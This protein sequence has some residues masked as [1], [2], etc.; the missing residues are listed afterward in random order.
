MKFNFPLLFSKFVRKRNASYDGDPNGDYVVAE[1]V[2]ELQE[3]IERIEQ[4]MGIEELDQS[5]SSSLKTKA[6]KADVNDFGS[7][8]FINYTGASIN[9]YDS[10]EKRISA[11]S[12]IPHVILRKEE[13]SSFDFFLNEVK[14]SGTRLYGIVDCANLTVS[15]AEY[16]IDWFKAKGFHGIFLDSFGF[17]SGLD[18][19][20][21]NH[22]LQYIHSRMLVAILTGDIETNV[23]NKPHSKNPYQQELSIFEGDI[24]LSRNVFV[25]DGIKN[26]PSIISSKVLQLNKAQQEKGISI[27]VED[28]ADIVNDNRLLYLYGKMLS[29]LYNFDG[30][31]L[32]PKSRYSLN[33]KVERYLHGFELG[34]WKAET[35]IY[36]EDTTKVERSFAKGKIVFDKVNNQCAVEGVGLNPLIYTWHEKQIPGT[37][38]ELESA[39]YTNGVTS[40]IVSA[41]ND[42]TNG[43]LIHYSKIDGLSGDGSNPE[44]IKD[45]VVRA[46]NNSPAAY[47]K[48]P[49]AGFDAVAGNDFIHGG[50]IDYIDA[51]SI[52]SGSM[53]IDVL[54]ANVVEA[55]NAYIGT[56]EIDVAKIGELTAEHIQSSVVDAINL[57]A[58][59]AAIG[60]AV[61]DQAAI[62]ALTSQHIETAVIDAINANI[63]RAFIDG[64]IIERSTV[65]STQIA[66][67]SITDAKIVSLVANKIVAGI[68]DTALVTLQGDNG[69]LRITGN[70]LQVFDDQ[71]VPIERISIGDVNADGT[72]YGL[73]VRGAD[74]VTVLY[75]EKGVY[76]EGI[77]DGAITNPKIAEA[78][79]D[80][81]KH[82]HANTITGDRL[83]M[84]S[85]TAREIASKT[86]TGNEIM[87]NSISANELVAKTITAE[88]GVIAD[89]AILRAMIG[90]AAIGSAEID[91]AVIDDGHIKSLNAD[92]IVAGTIKA[93]YV[94][95]GPG[96]NFAD[97][98]SPDEL[99]EEME[100]RIPYRVE[101]ISSNG[102][103]FKNGVV[104]TI[105]E[106]KVYK[107]SE[108][109]T[110][111]IESHRFNWYRVGAD[112]QADAVWNAA[113]TGVKTVTITGADV[114]GRATFLCE[115]LDN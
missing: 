2:N 36:V 73:R 12:Y 107:G 82:I 61:I 85:I 65:G 74:G 94:E 70:R 103:A 78:A 18:R 29:T 91:Q 3:S 46:I 81:S 22:L 71:T 106:P 89:A 6:D 112:G 44:T 11:F 59:N 93:R 32:A 38:V 55:I 35:P 40:R 52:K 4:V 100:G 77:T 83:V 49:G 88:S 48:N 25:T 67:G 17:E 102:I 13:S 113:H 92:K 115:V 69:H 60:Q 66:D 42:D 8:M 90:N 37:A 64:A 26:D 62:G 16:E 114:L 5:I 43:H 95:V 7:P 104:S 80:G 105:L 39:D 23:M 56:A 51:S 53:S 27:F 99:R 15:A 109:I 110:A 24:Y 111:T 33:E 19:N 50:V 41:I 47:Q 84:D 98:Y 34:K 10:I 79:V 28:T 20:T 54:K 14:K 57:Y 21:Q 9:T 63:Q 30:Y 87:A 1:D 108:D 31:S 68:I 76:S 97:G 72:L 101:I 75:D 96:T 45:V 58:E 86:I